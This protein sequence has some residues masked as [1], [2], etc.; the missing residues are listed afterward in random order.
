M[1]PTS[2]GKGLAGG[3]PEHLE[4]KTSLGAVREVYEEGGSVPDCI[5]KVLPR[6]GPVG[7]TLWV[8]NLGVDGRD[9]AKSLGGTCEFHA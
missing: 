3:S 8:G 9:S 2:V 4:D 6:G 5:R 7:T 1:G